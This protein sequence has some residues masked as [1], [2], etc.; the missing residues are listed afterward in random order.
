MSNFVCNFTV[1]PDFSVDESGDK[2]NFHHIYSCN[3]TDW[4]WYFFG[5]VQYC[6]KWASNTCHPKAM[7]TNWIKSDSLRHWF[8]KCDMHMEKSLTEK[9]VSCTAPLSVMLC[10]VGV[11][12]HTTQCH[13][14]CS[15]TVSNALFSW[16]ATT[17]H[18]VPYLLQHHCH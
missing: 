18:S 2:K 5:T 14:C 12:Q 9:S 16:C 4:K 3:E 1:I 6:S 7:D 11:P 15:T 8:I 13:I 17:W 10:S